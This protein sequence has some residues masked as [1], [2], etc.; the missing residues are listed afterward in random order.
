MREISWLSMTPALEQLNQRWK[1]VGDVRGDQRK[2]ARDH[3]K[4]AEQKVVFIQ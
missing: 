2:R 1:A 3:C 4:Q